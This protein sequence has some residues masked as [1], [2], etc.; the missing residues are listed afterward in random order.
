[1][2]SSNIFISYIDIICSI[3]IAQWKKCFYNQIL[4]KNIISNIIQIM[5][6]PLVDIILNQ[7]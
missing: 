4:C 5:F 6:L 1:M 7:K 3:F 2:M